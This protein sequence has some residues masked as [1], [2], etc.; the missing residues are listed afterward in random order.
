M[1]LL[2]ARELGFIIMDMRVRFREPVLEGDQVNV[3]TAL[4]TLGSAS[5]EVKQLMHRNE[6]VAL[7]SLFHFILVQ[8]ESGKSVPIDGQIRE[9]LLNVIERDA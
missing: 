6:K 2:R 1:P 7:S 3:S 8:R 5:G 4:V 9:L